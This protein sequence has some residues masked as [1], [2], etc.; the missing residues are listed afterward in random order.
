VWGG[1]AVL[2]VDWIATAGF[3]LR[4]SLKTEVQGFQLLCDDALRH[5][6]TQVLHQKSRTA[7][8]REREGVETDTV[9]PLKGQQPT[10]RGSEP[11][12]G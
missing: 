11:V 4:D 10:D 3:H 2:G 7:V 5:T 12:G 6:P 8:L 9:F 1:R